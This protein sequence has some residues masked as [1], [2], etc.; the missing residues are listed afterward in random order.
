MKATLEQ[1]DLDGL[2]ILKLKGSMTTEG[3]A[4]VNR[5]FE[6]ITHRPGVR[7]VVDLTHVDIITTPAISMF[8][9]AA[10]SAAHSAGRIVFTESPPP[11][12]DVLRRLRLHSVL[13]T[14]SG[15][16]EAIKAVRGDEQASASRC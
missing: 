1:I 6:E 8:I 5:Q 7:A 13:T 14:V 15:L 2:V 4:Q 3:L 11:V 12:R 10:S 16:V 9:A